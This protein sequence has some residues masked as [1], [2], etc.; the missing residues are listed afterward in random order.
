SSGRSLLLW[1]LLAH[2][3]IHCWQLQQDTSEQAQED[4]SA[5]FKELV[6]G[7]CHD[8]FHDHECD[9][10]DG[11]H[12]EVRISQLTE[13]Q[14]AT[15]DKGANQVPE[16]GEA[17]QT[18]THPDPIEGVMRDIEIVGVQVEDVGQRDGLQKLLAKTKAQQW[19]QLQGSTEVELF[20]DPILIGGH[21]A[22]I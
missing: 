13:D 12:L 7:V 16:H 19:I 8:H 14:E 2:H 18:Q 10:E 17:D 4:N 1:L 15:H 22:H 5:I 3:R 21:I 9:A 6:I 11:H 20:I